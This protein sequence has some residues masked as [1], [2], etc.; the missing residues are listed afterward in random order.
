[1]FFLYSNPALEFSVKWSGRS[2]PLSRTGKRVFSVDR[3]CSLKR[4]RCPPHFSCPCHRPEGYGAMGSSE[5]VTLN[6]S[7]R[8]S[9]AECLEANEG[10]PASPLAGTSLLSVASNSFFRGRME[11]RRDITGEK[12]R[13]K[14]D[15]SG[16]RR[17]RRRRI[18]RRRWWRKRQEKR[19]KGRMKKR[20]RRRRLKRKSKRKDISGGRLRGR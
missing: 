9:S 20:K 8:V 1:M 6:L 5:E 12:W 19:M 16:R 2:V 14:H 10:P 11:G 4:Q 7:T 18:K 3:D 15:E 13:R 17:R